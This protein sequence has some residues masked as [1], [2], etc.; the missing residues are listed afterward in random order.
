MAL[1]VVG[2]SHHSAP[3][4]VRERFVVPDDASGEMLRDLMAAGCEEAVLLSTCNRTELYLY[5]PG[6]HVE[7]DVV[8]LRAL[9]HASGYDAG[10]ARGYLYVLH[11]EKAARHLFRVVGSL[12]SMVLGEA[13]IQGQVRDAYRRAVEIGGDVVTVGPVLSRLFETALAVGGRIRSET[14][15]GDGAA[16]VPSAAV[17]LARKIF[18]RLDGRTALVL[19]AGEMAGLVAARLRA[20]GA[21]GV[22]VTNRSGD[23]AR[24]IEGTAVASFDRLPEL[25]VMADV[26]VSATSAPHTVVARDAVA[27]AMRA[28]RRRPLMIVDIAVPRDVEPE[29]GELKDVFLYDLDDLGQVV[30]GTLERRRSEVA[31]AEKLIEEGTEEFRAWYRSRAVVPL[32]RSLRERAES[33]RRQEVE[34]ALG[35]LGPLTPAQREAV[36]TLTR[37]LLAKV[38]H[39]PTTR[40]REAVAQ[41]GGGQVVEAA[42]FLFGIDGPHANGNGDAPETGGSKEE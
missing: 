29:A 32:I 8:G 2:I 33:V 1:S 35:R 27:Q 36:E 9:C 10:A 40:I 19:G 21:A 11:E 28:R 15:L 18:G 3:L 5:A 20:E 17:D 7:G 13:Q 42:R 16:S 34:R 6:A 37:Q 38:L 24:D 25:L 23:L 22:I 4:E 41:D 39:E 14:G 30:D 31:R 12:D 26:V